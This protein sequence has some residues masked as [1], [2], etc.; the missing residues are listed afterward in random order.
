MR[1]LASRDHVRLIAAAPVVVGAAR[2]FNAIMWDVAADPVGLTVQALIEPGRCD[3]DMA[4]VAHNLGVCVRVRLVAW[5][6][7]SGSSG[8]NNI[9]CTTWPM[10]ERMSRRPSNPD[11]PPGVS[12][13]VGLNP[14]VLVFDEHGPSRVVTCIALST[15]GYLCTAVA[16]EGEVIAAIDRLH[17]AAIIYEYHRRDGSARREL[18]AR[19]RALAHAHGQDVVLIAISALDAPPT[20]RDAESI[21]VYLVKPFE[22]RDVEAALQHLRIQGVEGRRASHPTL[23]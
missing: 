3:R 1:A 17:P 14:C 8:S 2:C 10:Y 16:T 22:R 15:A 18:G 11:L 19:M 7:I 5:G 23:T 21:D 4:V 13:I 6:Q 12:E 9:I 20:L